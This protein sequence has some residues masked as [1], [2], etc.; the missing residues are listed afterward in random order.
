M[1]FAFVMTLDEIVGKHNGDGDTVKE[2]SY[3]N[4]G[5]SGNG[6]NP[7]ANGAVR[8]RSIINCG[9]RGDELGCGIEK[10]ESLYDKLHPY[11]DIRPGESGSDYM[12]RLIFEAEW[13]EMRKNPEL[14][15]ERISALVREIENT[16]RMYFDQYLR[17]N[18]YVCS[19]CDRPSITGVHAHCEEEDFI[20]SIV[21]PEE[22]SGEDYR[23]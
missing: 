6:M 11:L 10:E 15:F 12:D 20:N 13:R 18:G 23:L 19:D 7:A 3:I 5:Y 17:E 9:Y 8:K 21:N 22:Y 16:P 4:C 2:P 14:H 1:P